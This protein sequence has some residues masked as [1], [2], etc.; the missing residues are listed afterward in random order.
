VRPENITLRNVH[1]DLES[2]RLTAD[3]F[4]LLRQVGAAL[5]ADPEMRLEISGH[6]DATGSNRHN[7]KLSVRRAEVVHDFLNYLGIAQSRMVL[8]AYGET[9][10]VADNKTLEGRAT[11]RR[12]EFRKLNP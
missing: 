11:N 8:K 9:K 12:V 4:V 5:K 10:P 6:A 1:F 2:S 7:E 3:G